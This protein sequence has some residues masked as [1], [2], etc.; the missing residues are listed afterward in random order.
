M[1]TNTLY[2]E[3]YEIRGPMGLIVHCCAFVNALYVYGATHS[4]WQSSRLSLAVSVATV[5]IFELWY[6]LSCLL[7]PHGAAIG[8]LSPNQIFLGRGSEMK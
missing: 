6:G 1:P 3:Y 5:I 2:P 8:T 4:L 7:K